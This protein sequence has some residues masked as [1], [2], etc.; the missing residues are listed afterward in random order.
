MASFITLA[1]PSDPL[2]WRR[3]VNLDQV[4]S[5]DLQVDDDDGIE[6]LALHLSDGTRVVVDAPEE[7]DRVASAMDCG[8]LVRRRR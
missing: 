7:V 5:V 1:I 4:T 3:V 8:L 2:G 6:W